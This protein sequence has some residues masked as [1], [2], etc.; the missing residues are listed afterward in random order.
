[1]LSNHEQQTEAL[2][3][4][5][6]QVTLDNDNAGRFLSGM[7]RRGPWPDA[8]AVAVFG[9]RPRAL[10]GVGHVD[11]TGTVHPRRLVAAC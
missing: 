5:H 10:L 11:L 4:G 3:A 1:M 2:L 6:V 7:R 9:D 8:P